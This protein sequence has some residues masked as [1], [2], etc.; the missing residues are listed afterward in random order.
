[1][2][3]RC[4]LQGAAT[5]ILVAFALL[6]TGNGD[7]MAVGEAGG[8]FLK[9]GIGARANGLAGAFTALADDATGVFWNPA[10]LAQQ[11]SGGT[12]LLFSSGLL[13][14]DMAVY[15]AAAGGRLG[16]GHWGTGLVY[17]P[18]GE[19]PRTDES[20]QP[21][22]E[23]AA[24]DAYA[25]LAYA[26]SVG[27]VLAL[28]VAAKWI[29]SR[30]DE[31]T[32]S[33]FAGD[34]GLTWDVLGSRTLCLGL[35]AQN[36]GTELRYVDESDPLPVVLRGGIAWHAGGFVLAGDVSKPVDSDV[37]PAFGVEYAFS[38]SLSLRAGYDIRPD[39]E[40]AITLGASVSLAALA[41]DYAYVPFE[42]LEAT[43]HISVSLRR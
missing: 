43:H 9:M 1:M 27:D 16:R 40:D 17:S 21:T 11:D 31:E 28:G 8:Q 19:I 3:A 14:E 5:T 13:Y 15:S 18:S 20:Q 37:H 29:Q 38:N 41:V 22:G 42:E 26:H 35:V 4:S 24:S 6:L 36:L 2:A 25:T 7:A 12:S 39:T 10:G 30:I 33:A 34:L 32:A 23:Y